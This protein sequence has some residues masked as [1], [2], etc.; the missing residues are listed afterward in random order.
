MVCTNPV[1]LQGQSLHCPSNVSKKK[2]VVKV[3]AVG[4]GFTAG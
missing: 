4:S 3:R 2:I 1:V